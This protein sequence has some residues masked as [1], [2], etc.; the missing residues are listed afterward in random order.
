MAS[1]VS[2]SGV[3]VEC[4]PRWSR[5][6]SQISHHP[7]AVTGPALDIDATIEPIR[8]ANRSRAAATVSSRIS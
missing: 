6:S 2:R 4:A 5:N 8:A 3:P 7:Y 1:G